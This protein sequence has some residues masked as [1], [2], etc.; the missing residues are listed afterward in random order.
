[1]TL[2]PSLLL[3]T[4]LLQ[5]VPVLTLE[6]ALRQAN[7]QNLDLTAARARLDQSQLLSR[8]AWANY[9]PQLSVS[10]TYTYNSNEATIAL[11]TG[12]IVRDVGAPQGPAFDPAREPSVDNPPGAQTPFIVLPAAFIEAQIQRQH[13]LAGSAQLSLPLIVPALWPQISN[14]YLAEEAAALSVENARREILF[15]VIQVYFGAEGLREAI[16]VQER[17]L[18]V[19]TEHEKDAQLR[20]EVGA[21]PRMTLL[22]AQIERTRAEQDLLRTRNSYA[23]AKSS[24]AVLL[25]R[26]PDFEVIRPEIAARVPGGPAALIAKAPEL[27]PD[28]LAAQKNVSIA[29]GNRRSALYQYLPALSGFARYNLSNT[30]GFTGEYGTWV[31]GLQLNW[32]IWDGGLRE[33]ALSESGARIRESEANFQASVARARDEVRRALLDLD[34]AEAN[35]TKAQEQVRMAQENR[36]LIDV[37]F[38][39]GTATSLEVVDANAALRNSELSLINE[40][41]NAQ[42]AVV[43]LARAAGDF[44]PLSPASA[45]AEKSE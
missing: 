35:L 10:G 36:Q 32:T 8:R 6:E 37:A 16:E 34:S 1:M 31:A 21:A 45:A 11:P 19:N 27:R 39:A 26:A 3:A 25:N 17:L 33:I 43:R 7:E 18:E 24:L 40:Q 23:A 28:V 29:E 20:V 14:A 42:L 2:L 44:D 12:Y 41:L 13:Q 30:T 15:A 9:L 4:S 5:A 38:N 22:R